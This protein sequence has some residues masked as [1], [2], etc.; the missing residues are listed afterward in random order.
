M[1]GRGSTT[2]GPA[3]RSTSG[4]GSGSPRSTWRRGPGWCAPGSRISTGPAP[5]AQP[6]LDGPGPDGRDHRAGRSPARAAGIEVVTL[7]STSDYWRIWFLSWRRRAGQCSWSA[8][9]QAK[10]VPGRAK[11]DKLDAV[12]LA[13]LTETRPAAAR[14]SCRRRRS[15]SCGTTPGC[16][17][18]W[19]RTGPGTGRGWRSCWKAPWSRCPR[20]PPS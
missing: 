14:R 10:N 6:R 11:T 9:G 4:S 18:G 13:K 12:W 17:P 1:P 7:E 5:G 16:G 2:G 15:G 3:M 19:S 20:W 8:P